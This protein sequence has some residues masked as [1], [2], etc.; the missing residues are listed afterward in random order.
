MADQNHGQS[1]G[2]QEVGRSQFD[3]ELSAALAKYASAEP[4]VGLEQ[5]VLANLQAERAKTPSHAWWRWKSM[6]A[7]AAALAVAIVLIALAWRSN[8]PS[9]RAIANPPSP[10]QG[11][12]AAVAQVKTVTNNSGQGSSSQKSGPQELKPARR[13]IARQTAPSSRQTVAAVPPKLD[14]FPSPQPLNEQEKILARYVAQFPEHAVLVARARTQSLREDREDEI[15]EASGG[16][17]VQRENGTTD[18]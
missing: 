11:G 9:R 17:Q 2:G 10:A 8:G 13:Q 18:K 12:N 15:R 3:R 4:R 16:N 1:S 6:A 7:A 14:Q 5:R